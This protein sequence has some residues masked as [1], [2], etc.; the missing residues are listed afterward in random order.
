ML[1]QVHIVGRKIVSSKQSTYLRTLR[2]L[3]HDG[4][5]ILSY[6]AG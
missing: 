5:N 2:F 1:I 4:L 6:S 3:N